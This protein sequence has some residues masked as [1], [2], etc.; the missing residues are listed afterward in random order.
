MGCSCS[1]KQLSAPGVDTALL[2]PYLSQYADK[3][4]SLISVLQK[5][6]EIYGWLPSGLLLYIARRMGV[7]PAKVIGVVTFYTQFRTKPVGKHLILLCQGTACHVNGSPAIEEAV[8]EHL[9]VEEG[10]ISA[11][12]LFTYNNVACLGCCSLAPAMMIGESTYG[13]LTKEK[14]VKI[15]KEIEREDTAG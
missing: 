1:E 3:E 4:G 7:P 6:Q 10:E 8:R 5:A 2:E 14:A 12:G 15:L 11:N 9:G 13:G